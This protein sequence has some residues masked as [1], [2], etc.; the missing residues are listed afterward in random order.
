MFECNINLTGT[1][2]HAMERKSCLNNGKVM[3]DLDKN[4]EL[5]RC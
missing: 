4:C 2:L 1:F 3:V 5:T